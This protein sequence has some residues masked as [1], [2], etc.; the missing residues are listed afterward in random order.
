MARLL[1][2]LRRTHS[3]FLVIASSLIL[4]PSLFT[5]NPS[6]VGATDQCRLWLAPS[7]VGTD[8]SPMY[9]LFAGS[10]GFKADDLIPSHEIAVPLFDF[11]NSPAARRSDRNQDIVKFLETSMWVAEYAGSQF[12]ANHSTSAFIPGIGA[13]S[14]YHSGYYNV[15][16]SAQSILLRDADA[17][18]KS[19]RK[20]AH[21]SRGSI[22][23][24][25][26]ATL[27][28]SKDIPAGMEL[29]GNYGDVWDGDKADDIYQDKVTRNDYEEA[30]KVLYRIIDFMDKY[31]SKM[32]DALKS[33]ILDFMLDKVLGGIDGKHAKT[34]RMLL[35]DH[36][37]KLQRVKDAGGTFLYRNR[38][39]IR[40]DKWLEEHGMC[41]DYLE[42][43]VSTVPDAGR[44]AFAKRSFEV[45][46]II[47]PFPM[48]PIL[49]E[50]VLEL[51][52][53]TREVV[54]GPNGETTYELDPTKYP[55]GLH[56]LYNYCFGHPESNLLLAP[57]A[58]VVNYIN[59]APTKEQVNAVLIWSKHDHLMNDH[60]LHDQPLQSWSA[61]S[62]PPIMMMLVA[63]QDI[64]EGDEIFIDYG[65]AWA[66]DYATYKET[67][68]QVHTQD[69][70]WPLRA[71]D[72]RAAYKDKPYPVDI[73]QGQTPY[74]DGVVT[75]CFIGDMEEMPDSLPRVNHFGQRIMK[76]T[77]PAT[78][79]EILGRHMSICDIV[80]RKDVKLEDGSMSYEY[81]IITKARDTETGF[82]EV[83]YVPHHAISLSERPYSGDIH[84]AGAFR[85]YI[86]IEDQKFPQE[87]RNLRD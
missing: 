16:W 25:Y 8:D 46:D 34:I 59:H 79:E 31:D 58:P 55:S 4:L 36:P 44:G 12:E 3:S 69:P 7:Y 76:W 17:L 15:E 86:N 57:T 6:F 84:T 53:E 70:S 75:V 42:V 63:N 38:E 74:P 29:F 23:P 83:Q 54:T 13:L 71:V 18:D 20:K 43:G 24:Y 85:R 87:W 72:L 64:K 11:M 2:L 77:S 78:H 39:M 28:A 80:D 52:N 65:D 37:S 5:V 81:S 30:D 50:E 49:F 19:I 10:Q 62:H 68:D 47:S 32:N 14:M 9:G 82:M 26:N 67:W 41:V 1:T 35:P 21:P 73:K 33:D 45:E 40:S 27:V 22:S 48:M 61:N 60:F 51:Y 56:L 66:A